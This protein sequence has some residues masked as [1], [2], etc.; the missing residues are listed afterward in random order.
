MDGSMDG[1]TDRPM[2]GPT[3]GPMDRQ[4]RNF[5]VITPINDGSG[6][7]SSKSVVKSEMAN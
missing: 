7:T 1:P 2:D 4:S 6:H 3:D 5:V